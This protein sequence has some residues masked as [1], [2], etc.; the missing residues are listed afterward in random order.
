MQFMHPASLSE[1]RKKRV[2]ATFAG[3]CFRFS[4][5]RSKAA[6]DS[7]IVASDAAAGLGGTCF[8][9]RFPHRIKMSC[10]LPAL[11]S[12]G[13]GCHV[14]VRLEQVYLFPRLGRASRVVTSEDKRHW[15]RQVVGALNVS[16]AGGPKLAQA[17]FAKK[18]V[19]SPTAPS[20][21]I[22]SEEVL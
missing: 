9:F 10:A 2:L 13:G 16:L 5:I 12:G 15:V 19:Q 7:S 21:T 18:F 8:L 6:Q 1:Y 17:R 22:T 3:C 11:R 4:H 14:G 20:V